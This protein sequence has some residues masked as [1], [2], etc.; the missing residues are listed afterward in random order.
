MCR[1]GLSVPLARYENLA[2]N[3]L[4]GYYFLFNPQ[5]FGDICYEITGQQFLDQFAFDCNHRVDHYW[6]LLI[7]TAVS[8]LVAWVFLAFFVKENR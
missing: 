7:I 6:A 3:E 2:C 5:K 4:H 8:L 1:F